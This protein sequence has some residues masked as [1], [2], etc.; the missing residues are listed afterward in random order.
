MAGRRE[1][2]AGPRQEAVNAP[3]QRPARLGQLGA[4]IREFLSFARGRA[5]AALGLVA[6]GTILEG[7]GL[8]MLVPLLGVVL[9]SGSGNH[10]LDGWSRR[11]LDWLPAET[12]AGRLAFLLAVFAL[13][14]VLRGLILLSRD[15]LLARIQTSFVESY[16]LRLVERLAASRWD[17]VARLRHGRITHVLA[18]DVQSLRIAS[19]FLV[20]TIVAL[21]ML[22]AQV[23]LA[24]LIS[25]L[26]ALLLIP[27]LLL[28]SLWLRPVARRAR[29]LGTELSDAQLGLMNSTTQFLGGLK[30]ALSQD[31]QG[32]FVDEYEAILRQASEREI[33]FARQRAKAQVMLTGFAAG[34]GGLVL[35]GDVLFVGSSPAALIALLVILARTGAPLTQ[36]QQGAQQ[37]FHSLPAFAKIRQL[38]AELERA[39]DHPP[40]IKPDQPLDSADVEFRQVGFAHRDSEGGGGVRGLDLRI[41]QGELVGIAGPSGAGKTTFADLLVGL[42]PPAQ[43]AIRVGGAPLQGER[44]AAWRR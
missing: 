25:P 8:L 4:F 32:G 24:I 6:A 14:M 10:A 43:G 9:G 37:I 16:R 34:L 22:A 36:I 29:A 33:A 2:R 1:H 18:S 15:V 13:L 3:A 39:S 42:Y 35:L 11:L 21:A 7:V 23:L 30:L 41:G 17:V 27:L 26:M 28:G 38:E 44:L 5:F 20:Q 31:L 12:T 40:S 19:Q